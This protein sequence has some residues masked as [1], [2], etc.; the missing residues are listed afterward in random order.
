VSRQPDLSQHRLTN[1]CVAAG[2]PS[3]EDVASGSFDFDQE[4]AVCGSDR[5]PVHSG[6]SNRPMPILAAA[7]IVSDGISSKDS[8]NIY[9][10][11]KFST[12]LP[13]HH[14]SDGATDEVRARPAGNIS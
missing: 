4:P 6:A 9:Y 2:P 13:L 11:T 12:S 5:N 8:G 10:L 3:S 7:Q 14:S 1:G